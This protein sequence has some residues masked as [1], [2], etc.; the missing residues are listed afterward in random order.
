VAG[1]LNAKHPLWN[2]RCVNIASLALYNYIQNIDLTV[3]APDS[4]TFFPA[5]PGH[6]SDVLDIALTKLSHLSISSTSLNELSFDYNPV[7]LQ[8]NNSPI[9]S[10]PPTP[11]K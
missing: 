8:I 4:P 9:T 3:V 1:D 10:S 2:S 6:C 11:P 5:I 7:L